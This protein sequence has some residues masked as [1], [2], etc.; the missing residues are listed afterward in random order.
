M[1]SNRDFR[2]TLGITQEE[3]AMLLKTTKSQIAMF[4]LGVRDLPA[5]KML[6]LVTLYNHVQSKQQENTTVIHDKAEN[7]KCIPML[8]RELSNSEM[9]VYLLNRELE[10]LKAK[11]QKS[12][13]VLE[14]AAFLETETSEKDKLSQGL[15]EV[16]RI[17][18]KRG[19]DKY[20]KTVQ[21]QC[22]LKL[23]AVQQYQKELKKELERYN[24]QS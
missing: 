18:A 8:E 4:E 21:L 13:S 23:K 5:A 24:E 3:L 20:G 11:Y 12:V 22:E 16:L 2:T 6:K 19:I 7:A 1:V 15:T 10:Q 9:E 17:K 14:L